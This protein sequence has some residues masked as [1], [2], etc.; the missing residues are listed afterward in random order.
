MR[1]NERQNALI[2][3]QD[4]LIRQLLDDK[5]DITMETK[6]RVMI[7]ETDGNYFNFVIF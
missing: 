5:Q 7:K 3:K 6:S 1:E 4:I 2:G